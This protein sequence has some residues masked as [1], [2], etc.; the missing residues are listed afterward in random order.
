[1]FPATLLKLIVVR[2]NVVKLDPDHLGSGDAA[3]WG[4]DGEL[5]STGTPFTDEIVTAAR[6]YGGPADT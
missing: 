4:M 2:S 3:I 1:L 6:A 5:L